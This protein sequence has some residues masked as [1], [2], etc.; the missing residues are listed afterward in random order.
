MASFAPRYLCVLMSHLFTNPPGHLAVWPYSESAQPQRHSTYR[1]SSTGWVFTKWESQWKKKCVSDQV[2]TEGDDIILG[3]H[4]PCLMLI[5]L[6]GSLAPRGYDS[7]STASCCGWQT[8]ENPT[9]FGPFS[10]LTLTTSSSLVRLPEEMVPSQSCVLVLYAE[11]LQIIKTAH[12]STNSLPTERLNLHPKLW[13][14]N[15]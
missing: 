13:G 7:L 10:P 6:S 3:S 5:R 4:R 1:T 14:H 15:M 11:T 9:R 12:Y 2:R 8:R